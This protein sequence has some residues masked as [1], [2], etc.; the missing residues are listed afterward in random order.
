M[1]IAHWRQDIECTQMKQIM[2]VYILYCFIVLC[3]KFGLPYLDKAQQPHEQ[4]Y[5]FLSVCAVL[6]CAETMVRLPVF[7]FSTCA[8]MLVHAI[9]HGG[10]P[11]TIKESAL[12]FTQGEKSLAAPGTLT[13]VSIR[14]LCLAFQLD[15]LPTKLRLPL[16]MLDP[17]HHVFHKPTQHNR[18]TDWKLVSL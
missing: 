16:G 6:S 13:Q 12:K 7:G 4:Y 1:A 5:P 8:Q 17:N 3:G 14:L 15:I 18:W 10:C 9:A 2:F 11:D